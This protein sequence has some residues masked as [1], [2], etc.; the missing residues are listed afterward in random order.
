MR[1][2]WVLVI[3]AG[4]GGSHGPQSA[5]SAAVSRPSFAVPSSNAA[6]A[7]PPRTLALRFVRAEPPPLPTPLPHVEVI[8]PGFGDGI[9]RELARGSA[10]RLRTEGTALTWDREGVAVSLDGHRPR[11]WVAERA[12]TLGDLLDEDE[13]VS[14]GPHLLLAYAVAADGRALRVSAPSAPRPWSAVAFFVG[15][16]A[17]GALD[18]NVPALFCVNPVG[19][20]YVAPNASVPFELIAVPAAASPV[21]VE[22]VNGGA[23]FTTT[24]DPNHPYDVSGL[25]LGDT[26]FAVGSAPGPRAECV[27]TLNADTPRRP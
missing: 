20:F 26:R 21:R 12:L 5:A 18:T 9:E 2:V 25:P 7:E 27:V 8:E 15:P 10:V 17:S 22:V 1:S 13:E 6:R 4:C 11:R 3:V 23:S 19:T 14:V 16:K 24:L